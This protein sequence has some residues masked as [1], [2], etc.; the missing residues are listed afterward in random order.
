MKNIIAIGMISLVSSVWLAGCGQDSGSEGA[1]S[2]AY[3]VANFRVTD[4]DS[5]A[6][7]PPL[8]RTTLMEHGA[9]ILVIDRESEVVEGE[10]E[11]VTVVIRF[12]SKE[13]ARAW[14]TS[15]EYQEIV[16]M[17]TDN[18]VGFLVLV[19]GVASPDLNVANR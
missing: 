6:A 15:P 13:A 8:A 19:A 12:P 14:Y 17:R 10:P 2:A 11:P 4:V 9:D 16:H 1:T 5:Y 7:Y 18:S 3:V